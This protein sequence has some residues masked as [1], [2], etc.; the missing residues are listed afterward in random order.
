MPIDW[1]R[2]DWPAPDTIVAGT[3]TRAG[4]VSRG[5]YESLNLGAHVGD[6]A[7]NVR[8]NRRRLLR[9]LD[10]PG[11]PLWLQQVHGTDVVPGGSYASPPQGDAAVATRSDDV[12]VIMTADCLPVMLCSS[13]GEEFAAAHCGWRSLAGGI[14]GKTV[15]AMKSEPPDLLAWLGPAIAQ[16]AFEVGAEVRDAFVTQSPA[17]EQHFAANERGRWQAD[18]YGLARLKLAEAGVLRVSGGGH[19]TYADAK[20][21]FSYRRDGQTGRMASFVFR[22]AP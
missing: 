2:A 3:T 10:M 11:E 17:A 22:R 14:L 5:R 9:A 21:F 7:G 16:P 20:R 18:L 12:L 15:A 4:G 6:D 1:L 8:E 19:C 13:N